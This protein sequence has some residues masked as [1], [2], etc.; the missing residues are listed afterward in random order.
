MSSAN[1]GCIMGFYLLYNQDLQSHICC[2]IME[3][4]RGSNSF[5]G[6]C[7]ETAMILYGQ[8]HK[9][10]ERGEHLLQVLC[11]RMGPPEP[12]S[13][14]GG[15]LLSRI[16]HTAWFFQKSWDYPLRSHLPFWQMFSLIML[17]RS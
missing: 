1:N 7:V 16:L 17:G 9:E 5:L 13:A 10:L 11:C 12:L 3:R 8:S 6:E 2:F 15:N 4:S 14:P